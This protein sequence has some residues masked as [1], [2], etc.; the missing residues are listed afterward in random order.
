M[1]RKYVFSLLQFIALALLLNSLISCTPNKSFRWP[2]EGSFADLMDIPRQDGSYKGYVTKVS[3]GDTLTVERRGE[4]EKIRLYG[5]DCPEKSQT[6]GPQATENARKLV[7]DQKVRVIPHKKDRY[8]RTVGTIEAPDGTV[9]N[10]ALIEG[11]SCWWY[12]QYAKK[13]V[14]L[15]ALQKKAKRY[16]RGLWKQPN[17]TPPWEYRKQA[18]EGYVRAKPNNIAIIGNSRSKVYHLPWCKSY[19]TL[20]EKNRVYFSTEA[21][22]R[23][24]G[25]RISRSCI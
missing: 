9:L 10:E 3:D 23:E 2:K 14:Q 7:L 16:R 17:P 20:S 19:K 1:T 5:V 12:E 15:A 6:Y 18:K 21:E 13:E 24:A 8:G 11:G 25:Y 22:A 4:K